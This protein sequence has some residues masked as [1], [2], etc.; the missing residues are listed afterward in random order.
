MGRCSRVNLDRERAEEILTG[1]AV[2]S[3]KKKGGN[4]DDKDEAM[5]DGIDADPDKDEDADE[6]QDKANQKDDMGEE[7]ALAGDTG[8]AA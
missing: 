4:N 2:P 6:N 1:I 5:N 8:S 3:K 7:P